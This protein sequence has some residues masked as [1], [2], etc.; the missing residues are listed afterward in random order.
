MGNLLFRLR[1]FVATLNRSKTIGIIVIAIILVATPLTVFIAQKQQEI[2]QRASGPIDVLGPCVNH[3]TDCKFDSRTFVK[4]GNNLWESVTAY[5]RFWNWDGLDRTTVSS[6]ASLDSIPKYNQPNGPCYNNPNCIFDTRTFVNVGSQVWESMTAYGKYYNLDSKDGHLLNNGILADI[7]R[8]REICSQTPNPNL[9]KFDTRTYVTIGDNYIESITAY[10]KFWNFKADGTPFGNLNGSLLSSVNRYR[11]GPCQGHS[12]D[13]TFDT[14]TYFINPKDGH[15]WESVTAYGKLWNW[16]ASNNN[17]L[18]NQSGNLLSTIP[19]YAYIPPTPTPSSKTEIDTLKYYLGSDGYTSGSHWTKE[20][21][22]V[23]YYRENNKGTGINKG[24]FVARRGTDYINRTIDWSNNTVFYSKWKA[25]EAFEIY[26]WD[27]NYIYLFQD[28][29]GDVPYNTFSNNAYIKRKMKIG[30]SVSHDNKIIKYWGM[31]AGILEWKCRDEV[32]KQNDF[33]LAEE[34]N[35]RAADPGRYDNG[36][37]YCSLR[38]TRGEP[39]GILDFDY[40]ITLEDRIE[41]FQEDTGELGN[42]DVIVVRYTYPPNP[43][44]NEISRYEKFYFSKDW[45]WIQWKMYV[46]YAS[47]EPG[48]PDYLLMYTVFNKILNN[49]HTYPDRTKVCPTLTCTP[50]TWDPLACRSC[51]SDNKWGKPCTDFGPAGPSPGSSWCSCALGCSYYNQWENKYNPQSYP[52]CFATQTPPPTRYPTPRPTNIPTRRPTSTPTPTRRPT[53]SSTPTPR[54]TTTPISSPNFILNSA[55]GKSCNQL[56]QQNNKTCQGVSHIPPSLTN[57]AAK[58]ISTGGG[59]CALQNA[60]CSTVMTNNNKV[61][62]GGLN[63]HVADWTYCKC[64]SAPTNTPTPTKTPSPTPTRTPTPRPTSTPTPIQY[65]S[66]DV[67]HNGHVNV[68]DF[69]YWKYAFITPSSKQPN[70]T[71]KYS[72]GVQIWPD[73]NKDGQVNFL[74]YNLWYKAMQNPNVVH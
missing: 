63:Y 72:N 65:N 51:Q 58:W 69:D 55:S 66:A 24:N 33:Y 45:G 22:G 42:Q 19:R 32:A 3:N 29:N 60:N 1:Y 38:D 14:R 8:Y 37:I 34:C 5:G 44:N 23:Y 27:D 21:E 47:Q 48:S 64:A 25:N 17:Q 40:T 30:E 15:L 28:H 53:P 56:C 18:I 71:Y 9:C 67:D 13:C 73:I 31:V 26:R 54:P 43:Y 41:N 61:C 4:I 11:D 52:G 49:Q 36:D 12:N 7:T 6:A 16:D 10:G 62:A 59:Y 2:R 39:G 70:G 50:G 74:D 46:R 68:Y 35:K 20:L 57:N